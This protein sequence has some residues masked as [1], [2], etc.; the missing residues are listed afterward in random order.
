MKTFVKLLM[1]ISFILSFI[2]VGDMVVDAI[3]GLFPISANEWFP[4]LRFLVWIFTFTFNLALTIVLYFIVVY[5]ISL[6]I[7][8]LD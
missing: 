5:I 4:I 1:V 3:M 8:L 7:G 6:I 2:F